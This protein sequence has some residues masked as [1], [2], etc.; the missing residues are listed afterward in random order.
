M[1]HP[2]AF[3]LD[4]RPAVVTVF[5][6]LGFTACGQAPPTALEAEPSSGTN[7]SSPGDRAIEAHRPRVVALGDSL[8]AGLGLEPHEA[9]PARLQERLDTAGYHFQIVNAGVSGD[10]SAG[11]LRRLEWA[12]DEGADLLIV[13][14]GGN[15]GLRGLPV[16]QM[17]DNLSQIITSAR[18]QGTEVV[19]AGMEAP[20]NFG[21]AYTAAFRD[22]YRQLAR[23]HDIVL[24]PFLLEGVAGMADLN[25]ADGIH[26]NA[27]GATRV[28]EHLWP[29]VESLVQ[30]VAT[31]DAQ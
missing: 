4:W 22:V 5:V 24:V 31:D 9:Y 10:T 29:A 15:D 8:T 14:L 26:P 11:G 21:A 2:R 3:V 28:A 6:T 12:L 30:R 16:D 20:P 19:L 17:K 1:L 18:A 27:E 25:Q 13:A 7:Q 23:E